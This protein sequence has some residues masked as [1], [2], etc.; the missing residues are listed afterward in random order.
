[1][2][3]DSRLLG[4]DSG[5]PLFDFDGHLIAIHS[6]V[7]QK[8]DQ[9]FHVPIESF[10]ANWNFF[11][12]E[13]LIS[14]DS[15]QEGGVFGV[16]CEENHDGLIVRE[17]IPGTAA[18]KAGLIMGDILLEVNEEPLDTREEFIIMISSLKPGDEAKIL[19]QRND[20]QMS[21]KVTLGVRPQV[22]E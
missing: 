2:Q 14:Y 3:T 7:S 17:V 22:G 19:Y 20:A 10:H 18:E 5:G 8:P 16:S 4:G 15:M 1:M 6:R 12:D 11:R 9:N 13:K 21:V